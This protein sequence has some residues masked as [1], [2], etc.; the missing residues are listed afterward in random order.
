MDIEFHSVLQWIS[1][2]FHLILQEYWASVGCAVMQCS[3]TEVIILIAMQNQIPLRIMIYFCLISSICMSHLSL[4]SA[5]EIY[6]VCFP[7]DDCIS[8]DRDAAPKGYPE[9]TTLS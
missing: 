5:S 6:V 8:L 7:C 3:N 2:A 9:T 4:S 1:H